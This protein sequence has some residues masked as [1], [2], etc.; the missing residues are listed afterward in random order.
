[1]T[2]VVDIHEETQRTRATLRELLAEL[3]HITSDLRVEI[4]RRRE[5]DQDD[6]E[7]GT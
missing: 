6:D 4:E 1:V 7:R 2:A 5:E 3:D